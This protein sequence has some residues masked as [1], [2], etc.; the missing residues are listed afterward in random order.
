MILRAFCGS[1]ARR[2]VVAGAIAALSLTPCVAMASTTATPTVPP[3]ITVAAVGDIHFSGSVA[4]LVAAKGP[5][6]PFTS[7][8]SVL[9]KADVTI[10]N[11]ETSLSRRGSAVP[12]KA[13]TFRGTPR[14]VMGL[15][16]AGFDFLGLANNHARDYGSVALRDTIRNLNRAGLAHAGAG[17][18]RAAAFRP[19]IIERNGAKVAFLAFS[20]IGPASF[21]ATSS[22]SGTAY[23]LSQTEMRRAIKRASR[24]ADYVIV[25][26]HWGEERSYRPTARQV[27][28]GRAAIRAGADAVLSHHPHVIQGVEYYRKGIIAY[29]LGNFVF[30]P[31]SAMGRDSMILRFT[32]GPNGVKKVSGVPC[33]IS[34]GKPR[35]QSGASARRIIGIMK[36]TSA[37]RGTRVT[38]TDSVARFRR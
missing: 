13:Y 26:F 8:A 19:A 2:A 37:M 27:A 11:L 35:V 33:Y 31:G 17:K 7:T 36:R 12:G 25:S 38:R 22:R 16:Y 28:Y 4:R 23:T 14:A 34:A 29:S 20:Q 9:R 15:K 1:I 3:A 6:A 32:L 30:S 10:G 24:K 21:R 18:D 5:K